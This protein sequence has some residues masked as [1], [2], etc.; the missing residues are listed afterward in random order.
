MQGTKIYRVLVCGSG[1][2]VTFICFSQYVCFSSCSQQLAVLILAMFLFWLI[3]FGELQEKPLI[4]LQKCWACF[5]VVA[6]LC[7]IYKHSW[8]M[9]TSFVE[10]YF[11]GKSAICQ[12]TSLQICSPPS[13]AWFFLV[14]YSVK[15]SPLFQDEKSVLWFYVG[16]QL[17]S[18]G[19]TGF[20]WEMKQARF[21]IVRSNLSLLLQFYIGKANFFISVVPEAEVW[22]RIR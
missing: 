13:S 12:Y 21:W 20:V 18:D 7:S 6:Q 8:Q 11:P 22:G 1:Y 19:F 17:F 5:P 15:L 14:L 2:T 3:I 10:E 9:F 16:V 4:K